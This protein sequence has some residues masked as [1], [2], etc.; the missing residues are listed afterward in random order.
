[1]FALD[2]LCVVFGVVMGIFALYINESWY[3]DYGKL[4]D[5]WYK[6]CEKINNGWFNTC[7]KLS[8][9]IEELENKE[10]SNND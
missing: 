7:D 5:E 8:Q 3:K 1:M 10:E 6:H 2:I 9:K 4:N